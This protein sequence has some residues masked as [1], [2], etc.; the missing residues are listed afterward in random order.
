[1]GSAAFI[2][3]DLK[4]A[5]LGNTRDYA[6]LL[7]G[8]D[9]VSTTRETIERETPGHSGF[10]VARYPRGTA[11]DVDAAV[12][13]ARK[14][15]DEGPWPRMPA[16]E[17]SRAMMRVAALL[18][19]HR[20]ELATVESLEAGK[21]ITQAR[22]EIDGCVDL[23][24]YAAGQVRGL[25]GEAHT[26]LGPDVVAMVIREPVGVVGVITP[27]NFPIIIACERIPWIIGAGN[28]MVMKP[29]EFTSGTTL[30][31]AAL[32]R[33]AGV[34]DGVVNV[35]T[36][37]GDPVGD[38]LTRHPGVDMVSFT[39]SLTVG[40]LVGAAAS[41][42]VKRVGLELG[43]KGPQV[44]FADADLDD[45]ADG[46]AFGLLFNNG[47]CCISGSR[48]IVH[49]SIV[50]DFLV[51]LTRLS[52]CVTFG[53]PLNEKT[54]VGSVINTAQIEKIAGYVQQGRAAGAKLLTGGSRKGEGKG[55]Y[56]E[57]TIFSNVTPTMSIANEEI[58]GP[59]LSVLTFSTP[60]EAVCLANG[61]GYGLS[62]SVWTRD[63][64]LGLGA[65]QKIRAG[66]TWI[67]GVISSYPEVPLGGYKQSGNGR[68]T[69]KYGFDQYSEFKTVHALYGKRDPW[70]KPEGAPRLLEVAEG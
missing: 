50:E 67:N 45:A 58:F 18:E 2:E 37:Y 40:R 29:S 65:I 48:L 66:K 27:W 44:I 41:A 4:D 47:Q 42:T 32:I 16:A 17:R 59:V 28:A 54:M 31:L 19:K 14:A 34:P 70:I 33:E 20:E 63:I 9:Y 61:T 21:P 25:H 39:G 35:V 26:N 52:S 46:A 51:R 53:D 57:P 5:R 15:F 56:F 8:A 38:A 12:K 68:E 62:A 10:V 22:N 49:R 11:E 64:G 55:L 23:W 6:M 13:A 69:G 60:E 24:E 3:P 43:G 36:G 1:M 7:G 30:R